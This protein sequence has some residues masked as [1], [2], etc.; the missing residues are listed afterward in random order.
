VTD[1][2]V[3]AQAAVG[4]DRAASSY[5]SHRPGYPSAFVARVA[6]EI[7]AERA[8]RVLDLGAGTGKLT[9]ELVALGCDVVAVEPLAAMRAQLVAASPGV[10]ALD[11][12]AE[13]IPLPDDS[14]DAV[15]SAQAFHWFDTRRALDE[16]AR[17]LRPGG[18]LAL[19]W[20]ERS[21]DGGWM[22]EFETLAD[23]LAQNQQAYP[24]DG[25]EAVLDADPR[26]TPV[27]FDNV[28]VEQRVTPAWLLENT[29]T[30]SWIASKSS[31]ERDEIIAALERFVATNPKTAGRDELVY[32]EP[33]VAYWCRLAV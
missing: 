11:G 13:A 22:H 21:S 28:D 17:V 31:A 23:S 9:R 15:T 26:F 10:D 2:R 24:G 32:H 16:I 14:V 6:R 12:T 27:Q 7:G 1:E 30:K 8:R 5:D 19:F 3:A 20:N 18:G 25:W 4:F 29:T 33:C